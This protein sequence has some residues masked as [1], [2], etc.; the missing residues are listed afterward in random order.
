MCIRI[1][2]KYWNMYALLDL[3]LTLALEI[4]M[5]TNNKPTDMTLLLQHQMV[6][7]LDKMI[8]FD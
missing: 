8:S 2:F 7:M 6:S 4:N 3:T 5:Y 1:I